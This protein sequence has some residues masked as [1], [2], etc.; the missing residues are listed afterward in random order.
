MADAITC[1]HLPLFSKS[2]FFLSVELTFF[3]VF[4]TAAGKRAADTNR[5][6]H[7]RKRLRFEHCL[8]DQE[9][10]PDLTT[11]SVH[12]HLL[13]AEYVGQGIDDV[14]TG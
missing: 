8:A 7:V 13:C 6:S 4:L 12:Q 3:R 2:H 11:R 1:E 5:M 9:L 10:P 14:C